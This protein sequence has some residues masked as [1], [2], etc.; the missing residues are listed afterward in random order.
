MTKFDPKKARE[1][2]LESGKHL[3]VATDLLRMQGVASPNARTRGY[4]AA[5]RVLQKLVQDGF[6][7][8][9]Y[10]PSNNITVYWKID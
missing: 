2:V 5:K 4:T 9:R 7:N 3:F 1:Q 6:L 8:K 10:F